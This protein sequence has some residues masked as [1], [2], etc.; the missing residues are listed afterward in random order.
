MTT[1]IITLGVILSLIG[2][3]LCLRLWLVPAGKG[4][5]VGATLTAAIAFVVLPLGA[6]AVANYQTFEGVKSV[7]ACASCHVMQSKVDDMKDPQSR[8]LAA[9]HFQNRWIADQQCHNCHSD[10]GLSGTLKSKADGFRHLARYTTG[11]YD[12]PVS[13]RGYFD[14]SNCLK[15]HGPTEKYRSV[16]SH[17][18]IREHLASSQTSCLN[19]HGVA[20]ADHE[21]PVVYGK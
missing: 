5:V 19:C 3:G 4:A 16:S 17:A 15:C 13:H 11:T 20:H 8:T 10:Y 12:N 2:L 6:V 14:N 18:T 9:L 1:L 7:D 21:V